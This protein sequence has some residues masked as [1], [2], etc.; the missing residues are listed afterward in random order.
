MN[1]DSEIISTLKDFDN[2]YSK[3]IRKLFQTLFN[4]I[5][6]HTSFEKLNIKGPFLLTNYHFRQNSVCEMEGLIKDCKYDNHQLKS[7]ST[8]ISVHA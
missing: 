8:I 4:D 5:L 6:T 1:P 2:Q 3:V 7:A